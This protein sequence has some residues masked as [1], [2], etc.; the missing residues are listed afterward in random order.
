MAKLLS[1][2]CNAEVEVGEEL[3]MSASD[4]DQ[5]YLSDWQKQLDFR[6]NFYRIVEP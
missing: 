2:T 6:M 5:S 1:Q 3:R 4:S